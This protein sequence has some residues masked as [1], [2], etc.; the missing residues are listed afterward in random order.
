GH[1]EH[2]DERQHCRACREM[3]LLLGDRRKDRALE[4][5]HRADERVDDDEQRE[6]REVRAEP[7]PNDATGHQRTQRPALKRMISIMPSGFG[8]T[9]LPT[10]STKAASSSTSNPFH[11][12]SNAIVLAGF[13]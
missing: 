11:R 2:D 8:G 7:E 9:F 12:F 10:S 13:P 5:D 4:A 6:L 1:A 3:K